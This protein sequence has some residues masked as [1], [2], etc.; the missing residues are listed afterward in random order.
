MKSKPPTVLIADDH[1]IVLGGLTGLLGSKDRFDVV[2]TCSDGSEAL[3]KL[4]ALEPDLGVLDISMPG[5]TGIEVLAITEAEGLRTR[6]VFL[7][8]SATDEQITQAVA[9]G[10]WGI[11]LKDAAADMLVDCLG[12]VVTGERWLPPELVSPALEREAERR[13]HLDRLDGLLTSR[14]REIAILVAEG[15]SNKQIARRVRIS[16]GTVKIHLHNAYQKLGVVNRTSLATLAQR[17]FAQS[18]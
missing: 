9:R 14:E 15:L 8:A 16:E 7:T 4:R 10:A 2:A 18:C 17:Y 6:V 1:P 5:L 3:E 13:S 12:K 11:M